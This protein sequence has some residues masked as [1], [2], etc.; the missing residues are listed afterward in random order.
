MTTGSPLLPTR[1]KASHFLKGG[2]LR[3]KMGTHR[4]RLYRVAGI[5]EMA[6]S[7]RPIIDSDK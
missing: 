3:S 5:Y 7:N 4:G 2:E 1:T 6:S